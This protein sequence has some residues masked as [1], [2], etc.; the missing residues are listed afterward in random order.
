MRF[1]SYVQAGVGQKM[2]VSERD[3]AQNCEQNFNYETFNMI[4]VS[5]SPC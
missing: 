2:F 5:L 4:F 1:F 3:I